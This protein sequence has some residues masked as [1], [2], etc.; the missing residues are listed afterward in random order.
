VA[1]ASFNPLAL[2]G[3]TDRG[4]LAVGQRADLVELDEDLVVIGVWIRGRKLDA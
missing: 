4:S 2:I 3:Q 1:A